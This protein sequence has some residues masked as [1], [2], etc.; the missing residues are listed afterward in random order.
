MQLAM[1][2]VTTIL[3]FLVTNSSFVTGQ[4]SFKPYTFGYVGCSNTHD[5]IYGY[6]IANGTKHLFWPFGSNSGYPIGGHT[7]LR[8]TD[9]SDPIW[10]SF[11]QMKQTYNNGKDPPVIWI[12]M[13][14][15]L[16]PT[17]NYGY[18]TFDNVKQMLTSLRAH[19]PTSIF[20]ISPLQSYDPPTLCHL[21]GPNGE[22][23]PHLTSLANQAVAAGL[24]LPGPGAGAVPNL[25]P[26]TQQT[27]YSDGCH[28]NG[29]PHGPGTGNV[30]LGTQLMNFFDQLQTSIP[31]WSQPR[32]L[33]L[34]IFLV[35]IVMSMGKMRKKES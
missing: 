19:A 10:A 3:A 33:G 20:Y 1:I 21:M 18:T 4:A 12:Q 14:E 25:G 2:S 24:A 6:H 31:E 35:L 17:S 23:I 5:T 8:W 27:V 30:F 29:F 22:A 34:A 7:V 15:N 13:C 11:D 26:L 32:L 16:D 9:P 28:P